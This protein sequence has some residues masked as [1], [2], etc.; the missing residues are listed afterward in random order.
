MVIHCCFHQHPR[1]QYVS[2]A[3]NILLLVLF[4][5]FLGAVTIVLYD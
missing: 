2:M 4:S 3:A 5:F 1:P